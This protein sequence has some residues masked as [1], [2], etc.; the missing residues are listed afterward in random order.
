MACLLIV[1]IDCFHFDRS[2][3]HTHE[4]IQVDFMHVTCSTELQRS[5]N[6]FRKLVQRDMLLKEP[7]FC[8]MY[9]KAGLLT[10]K[11]ISTTKMQ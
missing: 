5:K 2:E 9:Y 6:L 4:K 7:L 3:M 11:K 1:G 10:E 8:Y